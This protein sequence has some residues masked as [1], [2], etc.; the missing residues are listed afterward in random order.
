M[1]IEMTK[2]A[3]LRF[4]PS[5]KL[6]IKHRQIEQIKQ[7]SRKCMSKFIKHRLTRIQEH[8]DNLG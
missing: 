8:K 7:E 4:R 3:Y 6:N 5:R 1:S 2:K